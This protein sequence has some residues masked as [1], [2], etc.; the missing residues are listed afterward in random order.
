MPS[1]AQSYVN[2]ITAVALCV[3]AGYLGVLVLIWLFQERVVFQP[4]GVPP[5][6]VTQAKKIP[7]RT[8]DGVDLF[9]YVV[10][11]CLSGTTVLLAF[12]G[13]A[14]LAAWLVP[15]AQDV[16]RSADVCVVL[17]EYR[18][19]D[20]L[21]GPPTY[22]GSRH[23]AN[24]ALKYVRD[25]LGAS[26]DNLVYFGHS[27]GSAVAAELAASDPP[28]SLILQSPFSSANDMSRR[29]LF[30]APSFVLSRISRVHYNTVARVAALSA[31][32]WV[33]HGE[34]DV[35]VPVSMGRAVF[36]AAREKGELLVLRNAGHNDV[37]RAGGA[38][39]AAWLRR[40]IGPSEARDATADA[41]ARTRSE[42]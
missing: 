3:V 1:R 5:Q 11:E 18:G 10:G 12:H 15:W 37:E 21:R 39:Y 42:P 7:Y 14:D 6:L 13:N 22:D 27:L 8:D 30:V 31:P 28:R 35:I 4:P 23:D 20:G 38:E 41:P 40:A 36:A 16:A 26:R 34:Q 19:Y 32:V 9:A 17:P 25:S 29:Y 2:L 24:A 33:A